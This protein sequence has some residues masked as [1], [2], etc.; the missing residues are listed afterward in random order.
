MHIFLRRHYMKWKEQNLNTNHFTIYPCK[1]HKF[2]YLYRTW[3]LHPLL[4]FQNQKV[5]TI[6]MS[7]QKNRYN[8]FMKRGKM[9]FEY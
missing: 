9:S 5:K 7:V 1:L 6:E 2:Q 4:N 3:N 8:M